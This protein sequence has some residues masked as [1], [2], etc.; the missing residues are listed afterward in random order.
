MERTMNLSVCRFRI[1]LRGVI[2]V[3]A[4]KAGIG[5]ELRAPMTQRNNMIFVVDLRNGN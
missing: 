4:N 5:M 3:F 1:N 2:P